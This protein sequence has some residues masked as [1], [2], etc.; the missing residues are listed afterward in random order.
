MT[1]PTRPI[2]AAAVLVGAL[3]ARQALQRT[4]R[5]QATVAAAS[6]E[7]VLQLEG[8]LAAAWPPDVRAPRLELT[9]GAAGGEPGGPGLQLVAFDAGGRRLASHPAPS[10]GGRSDD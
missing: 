2:S 10:P 6:F 8:E 3:R 9:W 5:V 1:E 7:E 4:A